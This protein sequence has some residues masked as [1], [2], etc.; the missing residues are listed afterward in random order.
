MAEEKFEIIGAP[1]N[2]KIEIPDEENKSKRGRRPSKG[3]MPK[4]HFKDRE[5]GKEIESD[6]PEEIMKALNINEEEFESILNQVFRGLSENVPDELREK[7]MKNPELFTEEETD[8]LMNMINQLFGGSM[9]AKKDQGLLGMLNDKLNKG[10]NKEE[11]IVEESDLK[12][13]YCNNFEVL[14]EPTSFGVIDLIKNPDIYLDF[15]KIYGDSKEY[16]LSTFAPTVN[17]YNL[18][19]GLNDIEKISYIS[20]NDKFILFKAIPKDSNKE[21]MVVAFI[22]QDRQTFEFIIPQYGNS[23][24]IDNGELF[25]KFNDTHLFNPDGTLKSPVDLKKIDVGLD[26]LTYEERKPILSVGGFGEVTSSPTIIEVADDKIRIGKIT[27]NESKQAFIFKRDFDLDKNRKVFDFYVKF[28]NDMPPQVL[29][30]ISEYLVNIDFTTN[31]KIQTYELRA[32]S[33]EKIYIELDLGGLPG[34]IFKWSNE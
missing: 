22:Q 27:S 5:T 12:Q 13:N 3:E 31:P 33:D 14:M 8:K 9:I 18:I 10:K 25:D 32:S 26:L 6:D 1:T 24:D 7:M 4:L 21:G 28:K 29:N 11:E 2:S 30:A 16:L 17:G 20:N 19:K 34:H 15:K 23:Y